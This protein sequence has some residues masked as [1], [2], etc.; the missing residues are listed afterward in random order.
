MIWS[1]IPEELIFASQP[2][3]EAAR[4]TDYQGRKVLLRQG[5]VDGLLSTEPLDFLD[6]RFQPGAALD[7]ESGFSKDRSS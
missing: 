7:I 2:E 3:Q 5:R 1:I 4:I 6:R